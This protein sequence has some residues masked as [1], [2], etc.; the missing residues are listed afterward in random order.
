MLPR[1]LG[2]SWSNKESL[3][4]LRCGGVG[5]E[6]FISIVFKVSSFMISQLL[7]L[8]LLLLEFCFTIFFFALFCVV[9]CFT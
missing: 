7:L 6:G 3:K 4:V 1:I 9:L 8:L 2:E 5:L